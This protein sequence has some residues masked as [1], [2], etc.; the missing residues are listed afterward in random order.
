MGFVETM[1]M[2]VGRCGPNDQGDLIE[3][4]RR[5]FGEGARQSDQRHLFWLFID[6]PSSHVANP[7]IRPDGVS[8][9]GSDIWPNIWIVKRQGR[10]VGHQAGI[11]VQLKAGAALCGASWAV[12]LMVAPE[13]R[14][15]GIAP[16]LMETHAAAQPVALALG[17]NETAHKAYARCG[18]REVGSVPTY[19]MP[20]SVAPLL[21]AFPNM[22][23]VRRAA[24][25]ASQPLVSWFSRMP[26]LPALLGRTSFAAVDAFDARL[27]DV[28]SAVSPHYTVL[29]RRDEASVRWRFDAAPDSRRYRRF[30]LVRG[31]RAIGYA[32]LCMDVWRGVPIAL[33]ADYLAKPGDVPALFAHCLRVARKEKAGALVCKTQNPKADLRLRCMGF[34]VLPG[35]IIAKTRLMVKVA[36]DNP[37]LAATVSNWGNWFVTM[38][39]SDIGLD[40]IGIGARPGNGQGATTAMVGQG[41]TPGR[42]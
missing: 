2:A 28:W 24:L 9:F 20:L 13:W 10:I 26:V 11:A 4:L 6:N 16:A 8:A 42:A 5:M 1:R 3:F 17:M 15:R 21:A 37:D 35:R 36:D 23:P 18:W 39:D 30:Y 27:G 34:Q 25:R 29:A 19:A 12:D 40:R 7:D 38:G 31:G 22:N 14:L 32:V 41:I 33:L